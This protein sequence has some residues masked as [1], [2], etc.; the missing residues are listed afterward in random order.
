MADAEGAQADPLPQLAPGCNPMELPLTPA[1]GYLLSRVDGTTRRSVLR[2]IGGMPPD[3]VDRCLERWVKDGLLLMDGVERKATTGIT[4]FVESEAEAAPEESA[5]SESEGALPIDPSLD[6]SEEFQEQVLG[7]FGKLAAPYH[8]ILGVAIDADNKTIKKA[9]FGLSKQYHPDRYFRKNLGAYAEYVDL[10]FK[11]VLE[12]YELLSDPA[13]RAEVQRGLVANAAKS[14]TAA[15]EEAAGDAGAAPAKTPRK[16]DPRI[17]AR[18]LRERSRKNLRG[19]LRDRKRKAKTFFES[20]MSAFREERWLEAA[21]SV[22]LAIAFD[23]K[24]DAFKES[25]VAV[26]T[27]AHEERAKVLVKEGENHLDMR[28]FPDALRCFDEAVHFRPFDAGLLYQAAHLGYQ[29]GEDLRKAKD[30]A[31]TACELEGE[32]GPYR[33]LLGQIYKAAGF[34]ANARR[35]LQAAL[36]IDPKDREA[37]AELKGL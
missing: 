28:A 1:E 30:W 7:F 35:E 18:R 19:G 17:A 5:Q 33:R 34:E 3:E 14:N 29:L 32:N 16:T 12:A 9:Y 13:T 6:I 26:Q 22:R 2:Q 25:F 36:R 23:P 27:K 11:R 8:E 10:I 20:G 4:P 15:S 31:M 37:A 24:N 21:G